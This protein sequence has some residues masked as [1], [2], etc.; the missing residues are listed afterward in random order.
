[1]NTEYLE[2]FPTMLHSAIFPRVFFSNQSC[3]YLWRR[4]TKRTTRTSSSASRA[5]TTRRPTRSRSRRRRARRRRPRGSLPGRAGQFYFSTHVES[6][7][8]FPFLKKTRRSAK[9]QNFQAALRLIASSP[10]SAGYLFLCL[11]LSIFHL[12]ARCR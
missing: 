2:N 4:G 7:Q 9:F 3:A 1:M 10:S 8:P 12:R 11:N 6:L 5:A